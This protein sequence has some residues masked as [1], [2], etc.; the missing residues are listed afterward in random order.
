MFDYDR[1][2]LPNARLA[3]L[4][5]GVTN[6]DQALA[7]SGLTIGY[8][9]WGL[10][11]HLLLSHL[12]RSRSETIIETG[13]NQGCTT[14]VLAQA[15]VD[16]RCD[17]EVMTFE[18]DPGNLAKARANVAAAGIADRVR[19]CEGDTRATLGPA[20]AGRAGIRFAFLDA[21]HLF[22]D[23]LLEFETVLPHLSEDAL[24]VLDNTYA[25]AEAG[26]DPRVNGALAV[27][28]QRHGGNLIN[29]EFVS[30]FTPGLAIWQRRPNL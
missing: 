26:E 3:E 28:P 23:V 5:A 1:R 11:Y 30:W 10:L 22:D 12:D 29:L 8:P 16:A 27:I 18:L 4:E 19:F 15:L 17:G 6:L 14:I 24:V 21:S 2:L 25:I 7:R 13:S 20:L 9:G